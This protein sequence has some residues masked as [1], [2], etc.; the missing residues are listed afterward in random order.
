MGYYSVNISAHGVVKGR[1]Y[2]LMNERINLGYFGE[3]EKKAFT[4]ILSLAST[5]FFVLV[6]HYSFFVAVR[7]MLILN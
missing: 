7:E 3:R 2:S 4:L 5:L 6:V 1:G